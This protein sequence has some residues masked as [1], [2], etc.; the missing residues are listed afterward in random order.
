MENF[1]SCNSEIQVMFWHTYSSY[2]SK[3]VCEKSRFRPSLTFAI[4]TFN[5]KSD[6]NKFIHSYNKKS[7]AGAELSM[8]LKMSLSLRSRPAKAHR[9]SSF[10]TF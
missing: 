5:I 10:G 2:C 8:F 6:K 1:Q 9:N 3:E 7:S 4:T